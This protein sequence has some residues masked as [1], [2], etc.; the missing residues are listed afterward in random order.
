[1]ENKRLLSIDTLRGMD[2]LIIMGLSTFVFRL[3][4]LFPAGGD[5]W[6]AA[7]MRHVDWDGLALMDMVFPTFLFIAGLSFPFSYANQLEKG[8]T[9]GQIHGKIFVRCLAL[10]VLG[11]IY[12][13][14]FN[15]NFP[16]RYA[17][18]L[19]RIG[20]AWMFAA[21]LFVHCKRTTRVIVAAVILVGYGLLVGL[22]G[23][24]DAPAGA[25]PLTQDG[26]LNG[27][28][29]RILLP[30]KRFY[31][32][33]DPEKGHCVEDRK[34]LFGMRPGAVQNN[35]PFF[36]VVGRR[37]CLFGPRIH[38][39]RALRRSFDVIVQRDEAEFVQFFAGVFLRIALGGIIKIKADI[40][41]AA[42]SVAGD[43][44][45]REF[46]GG[47]ERISDKVIFFA[48]VKTRMYS[49]LTKDSVLGVV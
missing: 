20:L 28:I 1:M 30:G 13:G 18:V 3:C 7:Q 31:G 35:D 25:G 45:S 16:Q 9:S 19:G 6:L 32:N 38:E 42:G 49:D 39:N 15:F 14:F 48:H 11:I 22:V 47:G 40:L 29:D 12:N 21:L 10:I 43:R 2:L 4:D 37:Q 36:E 17:S 24:P 34:S 5:C 44:I 8:R 41:R 46:P 26:C 27:W 33:F 23:A